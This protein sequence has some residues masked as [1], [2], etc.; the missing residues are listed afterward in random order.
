M[1]LL[2]MSV[3]KQAQSIL[4]NLKENV[5]DE[6]YFLTADKHQSFLQDDAIILS[7]CSQAYPD[8]PE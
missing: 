4:N 5:K 6:V 2:W 7:V 3:A 8:Y 1:V